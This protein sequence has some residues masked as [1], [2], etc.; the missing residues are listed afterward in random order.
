MQEN[1]KKSA[2]FKE[3]KKKK[4]TYQLQEKGGIIEG[5]EWDLQETADA[6]KA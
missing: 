6:S 2:Q 3:K 5:K 4:K 1:E